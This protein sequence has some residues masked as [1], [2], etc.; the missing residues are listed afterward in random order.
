MV[1]YISDELF[2]FV[3]NGRPDDDEYNFQTLVK[4]LTSRCISSNPLKLGWGKLKV[5]VEREKSLL[6][7]GLVYSDI[8]CY[9]D[10]PRNMLARHVAK[11]GSF[12]I[13]FHR[14]DMARKGARPVLYVPMTSH[15]WGSPYGA[16]LLRDI[17]AKFKGFLSHLYD[18]IEEEEE[19]PSETSRHLAQV[20]ASPQE[21]ILAL[22]GLL[23]KDFM[24]YIKPYDAE[25]PVADIS[26]FY[27]EREWRRQ[28][29]L[30][31]ELADVTAIV[32]KAG[33]EGRLREAIPDY[34]GSIVPI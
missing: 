9:C 18:P 6:K 7:E 30:M 2:H 32:M 19:E 14:V 27:S 4:I 3:G 28:G 20:P 13:G 29:G 16:T 8:T 15:D 22:H 5:T 33:D 12:G 1:D 17:E 23:T 24:A 21:A 34:R 25:L 10:I 31:F 11:Y 26:Y